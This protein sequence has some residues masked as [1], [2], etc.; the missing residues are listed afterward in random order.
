MSNHNSEC[1]RVAVGLIREDGKI[2]CCQRRRESRYGLQW[3]FPGGKLHPGETAEQ[4]LKRELS[5][6]LGI[7][8]MS[9]KPYGRHIQ[10]Y[11]DGGIFEVNYFLVSK[12]TGVITNNSFESIYWVS[13]EEF[14]SI[15]FLAGNEPIL[16]KL[17]E[18]V[19]RER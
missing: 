17:K 13:P 4:C 19:N 6:E 18:D 2:L 9:V 16:K 10:S 1:V 12:Y 8:V 5:E 11:P 14:H 15:D 7:S 3:E